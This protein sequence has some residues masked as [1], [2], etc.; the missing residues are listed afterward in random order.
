MTS[1]HSPTTS[2]KE[3]ALKMDRVGF[4][5][6]RTNLQNLLDQHI[7]RELSKVREEIRK[8]MTKTEQG[9]MAPG[10]KRP[11]IGHL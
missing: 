7:E 6:F 8:L 2:W 10:D 5:S 9:I 1:T 3:Q 4:I 11:T